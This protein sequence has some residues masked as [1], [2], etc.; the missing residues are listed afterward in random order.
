MAQ[1][2]LA[3]RINILKVEVLNPP[4]S[5]EAIGD[6]ES[7]S[8]VTTS[9]FNGY[10]YSDHD[11]QSDS[12]ASNYDELMEDIEIVCKKNQFAK[13]SVHID[14]RGTKLFYSSYHSNPHPRQMKCK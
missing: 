7:N 9:T 3:K 1:F 12:D 5:T 2:F 6:L 11:N 10:T 14:D 13:F 4:L 8:N